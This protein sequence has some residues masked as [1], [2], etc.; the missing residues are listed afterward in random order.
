MEGTSW[1]SIA[2]YILIAW[3]L[4]TRFAPVR[5]LK[6][7]KAGEFKQS[8][9][10]SPGILLLDV[11]EPQEYQSGF[12]PGAI[13]VPLSQLRRRARELSK[14]KEIFLYCQS[15]LRSKQAAK[16][17]KQHGFTQLAHLHGGILSWTGKTTAKTPPIS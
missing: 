16:I 5:G 13:N 15:G 17:L 8:L 9:E 10:Q 12:I 4:I 2:I 11:R 6:V 3:F 7:L 1:A 14:D